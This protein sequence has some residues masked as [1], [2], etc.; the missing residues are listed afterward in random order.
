MRLTLPN[1]VL[2]VALL[3]VAIVPWA[4]RPAAADRVVPV[5]IGAESAAVP[6]AEPRGGGGFRLSYDVYK[7]GFRALSLEFDVALD[8]GR[9]RTDG[10]LESAGIIGW[11]FEWRLEGRRCAIELACRRGQSSSRPRD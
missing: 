6:P 1:A 8:A 2:A 5:E 9:Y 7:S 10:R 3:T 11:L 4:V